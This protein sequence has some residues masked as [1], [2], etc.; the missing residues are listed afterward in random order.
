MQRKGENTRNSILKIAGDLFSEKGFT[1][2]SMQDFC[3]RLNMSR[4]GLYRH[5]DSTTSIFL[6]MLEKENVSVSWELE[7]AIF[8]GVP[9]SQL[10]A[11]FFSDQKSEIIKWRGRLSVALYEFCLSDEDKKDVLETRYSYAMQVMTR[12]IQ[13][14]QKT[15]EFTACN[16]E[17]IA[18]HIILF[19]EG[20]K[21]SSSIVS[22]TEVEIDIQFKI[23]EKNI[24]QEK[25]V[26]Y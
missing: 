19:C 17:E 16:A 18:R 1:A 22:I 9:A 26:I 23:L 13:Y 15:G 8:S 5:F 4:G 2:V 7:K 14:G 24:R 3:D 20:L 11:R 12:L 25:I 10:I 6:A 21:I